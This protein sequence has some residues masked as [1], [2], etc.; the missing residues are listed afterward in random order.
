MF[1]VGLQVIVPLLVNN[2]S[3]HKPYK[4]YFHRT[5]LM[6][7][8]FLDLLHLALVSFLLPWCSG[9]LP[10]LPGRV[11]SS[12]WPAGEGPNITTLCKLHI[13]L[14]YFVWALICTILNPAASMRW[15][16]RL[17]DPAPGVAGPALLLRVIILA[18]VQIE[19]E[20]SPHHQLFS[21]LERIR[22]ILL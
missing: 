14:T 3:I 8:L 20:Y 17:R 4:I 15:A 10:P 21:G 18:P 9:G 16:K 19:R 5:K 13:S 22:S 1:L 12:D 6:L 11:W 2:D 7:I